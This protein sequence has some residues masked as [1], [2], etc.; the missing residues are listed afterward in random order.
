MK[1][2]YHC[3]NRSR[4][5]EALEKGF[6]CC[7]FSLSF[8][9][10]TSPIST[11]RVFSAPT[12]TWDRLVCRLLFHFDRTETCAGCY[13]ISRW[14]EF[15]RHIYC[16]EAFCFSVH[17]FTFFFGVDF[18][19]LVLKKK[20]EVSKNLWTWRNTV[21]AAETNQCA[22]FS[23]SLRMPKNLVLFNFWFFL[24][25]W[26]AR[27]TFKAV[28]S[29]SCLCSHPS[30]LLP[31]SPFVVGTHELSAVFHHVKKTKKKHSL[32][33][34]L[35]SLWET[36][37]YKTK[38]DKK[39]HTHTCVVVTLFCCDCLRFFS[40]F[41]PWLYRVLPPVSHPAHTFGA[42]HLCVALYLCNS[43]ICDY[44]GLWF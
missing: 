38:A 18:F 3:L 28:S 8:C 33:F 32:S 16:L 43:C 41:S 27:E 6:F 2:Y 39:R 1:L 19:F 10:F 44:D 14:L 7:F 40:F 17:D 4:F 21:A 42:S 30:P 11:R 31:P 23:T 35:R 26:R 12:S 20:K 36:M 29:T 22:I 24:G 5:Y 13:F 25:R 34:K 37:T 15:I 9:P